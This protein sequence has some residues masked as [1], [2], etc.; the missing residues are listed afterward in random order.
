MFFLRLCFS[1]NYITNWDIAIIIYRR[2][3]S[4]FLVYNTCF[5]PL[6]SS[7]ESMAT[8]CPW[9][10]DKIQMGGRQNTDPQS[11][12]YLHWLLMYGLT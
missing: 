12:D 2:K 11:M 6:E 5:S 7:N 3:G 4:E 9:T 8:P 1:F 10:F